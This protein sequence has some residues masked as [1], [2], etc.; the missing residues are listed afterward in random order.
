MGI[1][2]LMKSV[3]EQLVDEVQLHPPTSCVR[4]PAS[5]K[6]GSLLPFRKWDRTDLR[7]EGGMPYC[8]DGGLCFFYREILHLH[9][10]IRLSIR[11]IPSDNKVNYDLHAWPKNC[12]QL[13]KWYTIYAEC[14]HSACMR[15]KPLERNNKSEMLYTIRSTTVTCALP[16]AVTAMLRHFL[17]V[18]NRFLTF[19]KSSGFVIW[20]GRLSV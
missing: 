13:L 17:K 12:E 9:L 20:S 4:Q 19:F 2:W 14:K 18:F 8:T 6:H 11:Q 15:I 3:T 16:Y 10:R 5:R 7:R 1:L